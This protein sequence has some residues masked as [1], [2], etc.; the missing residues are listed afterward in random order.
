MSPRPRRDPGP[1]PTNPR[2]AEPSSPGRSRSAPAAALAAG[3]FALLVA[4]GDPT[5][6]AAQGG[7]PD[8]EALDVLRRL[9]A[10]LR[11]LELPD[12]PV[13]ATGFVLGAEA[14]TAH[15]ELT[16]SDGDTLLV[17]QGADAWPN[18]FRSSRFIP[19][20]EYLQANQ[21][22]RAAGIAMAR[23]LEDV[24]VYVAPSFQG[25]NLLLTNLTGHPCVAVPDGF[26]DETSPTSITFCGRMYGEDAALEAARAYQEATGWEEETPPRFTP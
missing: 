17:R 5:P 23:E 21:V 7:D 20:V 8:R 19:A 3:L 12:L 24:D 11:P 10:D 2:R 6:A 13:G 9:G 1:A 18:V 25:G 22:R 16:R 15:D 26:V 14:A 4:A